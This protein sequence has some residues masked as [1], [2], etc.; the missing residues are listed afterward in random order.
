M[1][2]TRQVLFSSTKKVM[3]S[4]VSVCLSANRITKKLLTTDLYEILQNGCT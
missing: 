2:S 4:P 3:F 1:V